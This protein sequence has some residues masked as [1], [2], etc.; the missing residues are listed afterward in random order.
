[1]S[2]SSGTLAA[3]VGLALVLLGCSDVRRDRIVTEWLLCTECSD[4]ELDSVLVLD[5]NAVPPLSR[6][7]DGPSPIVLQRAEA[8][9]GGQYEEM[10]AYLTSRGE[11]VPLSRP[12][13]VDDLLDNL[14]ALFRVR[15]AEG[16]YAIDIAEADSAIKFLLQD[17]ATG[18]VT[19]RPDVAA[20]IQALVFDR[21]GAIP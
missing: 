13:Y 18:A 3:G 1:M 19:L 4:A 5:D 2:R 16:L 10:A 14:E 11:P 17:Q 7:L 8:R 21:L 9:F 12:D 20:R 15:A 6:A